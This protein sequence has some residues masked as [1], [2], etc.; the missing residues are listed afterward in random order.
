MQPI[1]STAYFSPVTPMLTSHNGPF[2]QLRQ[3]NAG[4]DSVQTGVPDGWA[5]G[6]AFGQ[7]GKCSQPDGTGC[8]L[9]ECDFQTS[10]F[11]QCNISRVS[12]FN[13]PA[14]FAF[15]NG[16]CGSNR[17]GDANCDGNAAFST[18]DNGG[19]SLRQC[20]VPSVGIR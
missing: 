11:R 17:C 6:R 2:I 13:I 7:N 15:E 20:N 4:G 19:P 9:V 12:G 10:D 3:L 5:A 8:T 14:A 1:L 16:S 18:A